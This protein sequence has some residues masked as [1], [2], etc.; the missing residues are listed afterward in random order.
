MKSMLNKLTNWELWPFWLRYL[1][2]TPAWLWFCFKARSFWF[3]TAS[4]PTITFGG[5]EGEGKK[6]MYEQLPKE[7]YPKTIYIKPNTAF[8][9]LKLLV[10]N[11]GFVFPFIV[12]PDVG[13]AGILFRK[14]ESWQQLN[15]YHLVMPVE[16]LVQDLVELP[17]EYSVFYYRLPFEQKGHITGFLQKEPLHVIGDGSTSL[18]SLMES[19]P[20]AKHRLQEL[21]AWHKSYLN[22]V[23]EKGEK[24]YLTYAANLNRGAT[25]INLENEVDEQLLTV[26]NNLNLYSKTFYYGRYDLKAASLSALK[27]GA[28]TALEYNGSGAEPNHVYHSGYTLRAAQNE[29]LKHWKILFQISMYNHKQG[30]PFWDFKEGLRFLRQSGKHFSALKKIDTKV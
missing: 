15:D 9:D 8:E 10:T 16:Y 25:F 12:K 22:E 21:S 3:F 2:I 5:F 6:E 14:I 7:R 24:R 13:M 20:N 17:V 23:L 26:I 29:I 27:A 18:L 4:N 30:I 19:H 1:N 11:A 28:F